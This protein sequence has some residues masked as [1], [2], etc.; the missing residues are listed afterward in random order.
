MTTATFINTQFGARPTVLDSA[1][2]L[3]DGTQIPQIKVGSRADG[4]AGSEFVYCKLTLAS[5]TSLLDGHVYTIDKDF[6]ASL[7]STS[8]S[9]R[10]Q[11]VGVG[12]VAAASTPAGTYYLWV[13]V[14]GGA[15]VQVVA[16]TPK[17]NTIMETTATAGVLGAP[18]SATVGSKAVI[19]AVIT[20]DNSGA[21]GSV[22]GIL[23][24]P[25]IDKTN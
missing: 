22:E 10:G 11:T 5:T 15:P 24:W 13:Q 2:T 17:A 23:N 1:G 21:T 6:N 18:T 12:R 19:G 4:D 7:I 14:A 3:G 16:T 9:P 20:A 25:S 8:N